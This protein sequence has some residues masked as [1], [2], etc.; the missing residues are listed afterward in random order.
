MKTLLRVRFSDPPKTAELLRM[1]D[2]VAAS[3]DPI[4]GVPVLG[5][6]Q[7]KGVAFAT[8]P[9]ST[10]T[11]NVPHGLGRAW[12]NWTITDRNSAATVHRSGSANPEK[13]L[14]LTASTDITINLLVW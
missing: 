3:L 12:T 13:Y 6:V 5:A 14:T 9:P 11:Q 2:N 7:I 10:L 4:A 8:G 1:Q